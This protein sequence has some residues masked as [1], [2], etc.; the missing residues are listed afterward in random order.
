MLPK[1]IHFKTTIQD[2]FF[3]CPAFTINKKR[4]KRDRSNPNP[5]QNR[6]KY[7]AFSYGIRLP[8]ISRIANL[9][10]ACLRPNEKESF[11]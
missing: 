5:L 2:V 8:K 9:Q 3:L 11:I 1:K 6:T 4:K 10:A 7:L